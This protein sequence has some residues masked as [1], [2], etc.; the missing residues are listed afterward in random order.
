MIIVGLIFGVFYI[1]LFLIFQ[2]Y[3]ISK[4][5]IQ[6]LVEPFGL[7]GIL[8]LLVIQIICSMTPIP[9]SAMPLIAMIIYGPLGVFVVMIGMYIAALIHYAIGKKLGSSFILKKF[10]ETEKYLN[11]LGNRDVIIRLVAM[12]LFTFVSFDITSYI[13]GMS[14]IKIKD[15]M[16]ATAI[17]LIPTNLILIL[18][19][20]GLFA[21][22]EA[23]IIVTWGSIAIVAVFLFVFYRKNRIK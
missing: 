17:G 18:V 10:P 3:K 7:Y 21:K 22:T 11:K 16:I 15:F 20:Y 23:D 5:E 2:N 19:G 8:A 6:K 13:A 9:D 14:S 1:G 12:R 4:E